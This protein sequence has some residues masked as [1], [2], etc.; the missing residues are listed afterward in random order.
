MTSH[1]GTFAGPGRAEQYGL[2][3]LRKVVQHLGLG[4]GQGEKSDNDDDDVDGNDKVRLDICAAS[5]GNLSARWLTAFHRCALGQ[6]AIRAISEEEEEPNDDALAAK[7]RL[8]YPSV[9]DVRNASPSSQDAA[10]NIGCH[11][12]PWDKPPPG[13]Q[14]HLPLLPLPRRGTALPP[15]A[16]H[17]VRRSRGP[18]GRRYPSTS[19]SGRPTCRSR[20]GPWGVLV[21]DKR[22]GGN[23][24]TRDTKLTG[25]TNFEC[26]V[27]IPGRVIEGLLEPGTG[28]WQKGIVPFDRAAA[29][30]DLKRDRPWND[31]RWAKGY[32]DDRD[33]F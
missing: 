23:A 24:A 11:L 28:S 18:G 30:Y 29:G 2:L 6:R 10:S 15:E 22:K 21:E 13:R 32:G 14:A 5:V 16:G 27:L 17:G 19:I 20:P 31:P 7:M 12:R 9:D 26:D 25:V 8:F 4:L 3:W 1:P 33:A